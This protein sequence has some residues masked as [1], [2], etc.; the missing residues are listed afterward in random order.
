MWSVAGHDIMGPALQVCTVYT[1]QSEARCV[2]Y[3]VYTIYEYYC[4]LC[5]FDSG[6][7]P[8]KIHSQYLQEERSDSLLFVGPETKLI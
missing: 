3:T 1:D 5:Q 4:T 6:C 7:Q 2:W 8:T